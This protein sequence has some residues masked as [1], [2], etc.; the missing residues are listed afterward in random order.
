MTTAISPPARPRR[1]NVVHALVAGAA[2]AA[3]LLVLF[4]ATEAVGVGPLSP[5]VRALLFQSAERGPSAPLSELGV[6][7]AFGA[8]LGGS[9]AVFANLLS[10][11]DRS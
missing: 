8:V 10:F 4:W 7:V 5:D 3:F 1:M 6:A 9:I 11:L 2:V